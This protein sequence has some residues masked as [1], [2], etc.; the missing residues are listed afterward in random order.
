MELN[1]TQLEGIPIDAPQ[2]PNGWRYSLLGTLVDSRGISYGVVQPGS[3]TANGVPI[4][5]VNN[6]KGGRI[7]SDDVLHISQEIERKYERTRL[8]GG[9]VLLSLVGSLGECAIVPSE[10]AGW[11]VA[12]A[13]GVI[14]IREDV[15]A[16]WIAICP[17]SATIQHYIRIWATTTVQATFNL[18]DVANLPIPMPPAAVRERIVEIVSSLD[19]KIDLNRRMNETLEAIARAIFKS[20]F[21]DFDPVHAKA[22]LRRQHPKLS[23]AEL[24]RRALPNLDPTIAELFPDSFEESPLGPIPAAWGIARLSDQ[25]QAMKGLSYKGSGLSEFGMPLHNLNSVLE[26]GEYKYEG[27][28]YYS[29]EYKDRHILHPGDLERVLKLPDCQK[30]ATA[31]LLWILRSRKTEP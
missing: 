3:H 26:G 9:E 23:N 14:P 20:W 29:G 11:N 5:R 19:D 7:V 28:K 27:I 22:A 4:V 2:L 13:V 25:V 1:A 24:S 8:R 12:R 10:L 30:I 21:V 15:D 17:R 6:L 31:P 16:R 18:R